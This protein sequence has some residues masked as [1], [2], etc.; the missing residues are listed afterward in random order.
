MKHLYGCLHIVMAV[1]LSSALLLGACSQNALEENLA[2]DNGNDEGQHQKYGPVYNLQLTCFLNNSYIIDDWLELGKEYK[3]GYECITI[4]PDT[5]PKFEYKIT[6][7]DSLPSGYTRTDNASDNTISVKFTRPGVYL[8]TVTLIGSTPVQADSRTFILPTTKPTIEGPKQI[9]LGQFYDFTIN[10]WNPN[11]P[12]PTFTLSCGRSI[13]GNLGTT[14]EKATVKEVSDKHYRIR[15]DEPGKFNVSVNKKDL[16]TTSTSVASIGVYY[17]PYYRIEQLEIP[18]SSMQPLLPTDRVQACYRNIMR[19]YHDPECTIPCVVEHEL[20]FQYYLQY[21]IWN[22]TTS[23]TSG[24]S[25]TDRVL[26]KLNPGTDSFMLPNTLKFLRED[27]VNWGHGIVRTWIPEY[28]IVYPANSIS[29]Q[30]N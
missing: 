5:H 18:T 24:G 1:V 17:K 27:Q 9:D 21:T 20:V 7:V 14:K 15:F 6:K 8:V 25:V 10:W 4:S 13:A 30:T 12:D 16:V 3:F 28:K 11:N 2:P 19:F 26:V 22:G 23:T 29:Y